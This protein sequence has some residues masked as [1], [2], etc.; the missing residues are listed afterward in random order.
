MTMTGLPTHSCRQRGVAVLELGILLL[1]LVL[2]VFGITEFG[3][4]FYEYN[5]IAK[6]TRDAVRY[7]SMQGPGD[8]TD[9]GK[10]KCMVVYGNSGCTG[11]ARV[12]GLTTAMVTV[13]D[14][15]TC[16]GTHAAQ[17][18]GSGSVNLVTVTVTGFPFTSIVPFVVPA[19]VFNNISTTMRAVL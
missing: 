18:T 17:P 13:C 16:A 9:A 4:A 3:R 10:A 6:G 12:L 15:V 5:A 2:I 8:P 7:L 19:M 14:S 1:P 11:S